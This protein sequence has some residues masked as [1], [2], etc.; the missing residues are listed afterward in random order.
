MGLVFVA[1]LDLFWDA[2]R[3]RELT[4]HLIAFGDRPLELINLLGHLAD[5]VSPLEAGDAAFEELFASAVEGGFADARFAGEVGGGVLFGEG[6]QDEV[7]AS[8][9]VHG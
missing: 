3:N 1:H 8:F 7:G 5:G 4:D 2:V 6:S 9:R